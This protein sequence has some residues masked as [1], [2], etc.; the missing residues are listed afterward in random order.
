[1]K[2]N[3]DDRLFEQSF[4][5][6]PKHVKLFYPPDVVLHILSF[7]KYG[8]DKSLINRFGRF[9]EFED[10]KFHN[11][12]RTVC[13]KVSYEQFLLVD[14]QT[15]GSLFLVIEITGFFDHR[16]YELCAQKIQ[17]LHHPKLKLSVMV[18]EFVP[19][20]SFVRWLN[21]NN[22]HVTLFLDKIYMKMDQW[23]S[24]IKTIEKKLHIH[25]SYHTVMY[26]VCIDQ[27]M[28]HSISALTM[29][30][31]IMIASDNFW[32]NQLE[33]NRNLRK[34]CFKIDG[35]D[36]SPF[37]IASS[38]DAYISMT[39]TKIN[40]KY[41]RLRLKFVF[42]NEDDNLLDVRKRFVEL[43][44]LCIRQL[45]V[46]ELVVDANRLLSLDQ[47]FFT[48]CHQ[49]KTLKTIKFK[50]PVLPM[51]CQLLSD[52]ESGNIVRVPVISDTNYWKQNRREFNKPM[53][54]W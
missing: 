4:A 50:G 2:R 22:I 48:Q 27:L 3:L 45:P 21:E 43:I 8:Q 19:T 37:Y 17:S 26:R 28:C 52:W 18:N 23:Q 24:M 35:T 6:K 40:R 5:K 30:N 25:A 41:G 49:S 20:D 38:L 32:T 10:R 34:V 7:L 47:L 42:H 39:Q 31:T 36:N 1:M 51:N 29:H 54:T 11:L 16:N 13:I 53:T 14:F 33:K 44:A 9:V 12:Y 15:Y 46:F